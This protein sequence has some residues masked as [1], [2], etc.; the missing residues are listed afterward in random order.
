[1]SGPGQSRTNKV[2]IAA[3]LS[4]SFIMAGSSS[5]HVGPA[6]HKCKQVCDVALSSCHQQLKGREHSPAWRECAPKWDACERHCR[7]FQ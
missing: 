1:M 2:F 3:L 7:G 5:A 4:A 6:Y